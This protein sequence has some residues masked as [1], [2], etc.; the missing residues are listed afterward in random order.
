MTDGLSASDVAVLTG[1]NGRN[2]DGWGGDGCWWIILFLIFGMFGWGGYGNGWGGNGGANSPAFQ[3]YATRADI[4]AALSTQGIES[5]IQ[6]I[7]TQLC[8]GFAGVNSNISNLGYQLQDCCCQTQRAVDGVNYNMAM[9]TNTIQQALCSG[10]RDVID[11]QNAGTQRIIDTITQDKIQSLQTELQS[12]QLQL[13]NV[14][15]TNNIINT[16]RPTPVPAYITCSPYQ[17]AYGYN[18]GCGTCGC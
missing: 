15:Q 9:Q 8:N 11:S 6:N 12:A 4:D 17:A 14:S 1:N 5:G 18:N 10:F 16:L 7:S 3:G 2:N 13:A